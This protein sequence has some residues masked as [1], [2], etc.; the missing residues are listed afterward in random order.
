MKILKHFIAQ[1]LLCL[2]V[3][4]LF[5]FDDIQSYLKEW[6]PI[7]RFQISAPY[8]FV[9][10]EKIQQTL[11]PFSKQ[12]F[13]SLDGSQLQHDLSQLPWVSIASIEKKWPDTIVVQIQERSPIARFNETGL[14][15]DR[16]EIFYPPKLTQFDLPQLIGDEQSSKQLL[17]EFKKMSKMLAKVSL[18]LDMIKNE[19]SS[20][21]LT[22]KNG[23][24]VIVSKKQ[25][26]TQ[27]ARFITIYPELA[28]H[29][30]RL[31]LKVDLRYKHGLAAK[32]Q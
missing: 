30:Q 22:L 2:L 5:F 19:T 18:S 29:Q 26:D 32:W 25:A 23:L 15:D 9:S 8:H 12:G 16:G 6:L 10:K 31:L 4:S 11:E 27:L 17:Q 20:L 14:I 3:V 28:N 24:D 13:L 21:R 7:K 1:S